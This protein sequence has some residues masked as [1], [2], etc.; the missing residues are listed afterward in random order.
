[1]GEVEVRDEQSASAIKTRE[2][3]QPFTPLMNE[4][5]SVHLVIVH[6]LAQVASIILPSA[7]LIA[8]CDDH[9][10]GFPSLVPCHTLSSNGIA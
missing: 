6:V 8:I 3:D 4:G 2:L 1:M 10:V 5:E 9:V 7:F